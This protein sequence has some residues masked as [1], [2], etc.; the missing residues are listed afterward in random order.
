MIYVRR[1]AAVGNTA[2]VICLCLCVLHLNVPYAC[3]HIPLSQ[4]GCYWHL[5]AILGA[6]A[7]YFISSHRT[8]QHVHL[9]T[10]DVSYISLAI[11]TLMFLLTHSKTWKKIRDY[12]NFIIFMKN[13]KSSSSVRENIIKSNWVTW[14]EPKI[15]A[16]SQRK[17]A[18]ILDLLRLI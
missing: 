11:V 6:A 5:E 10:D 17:N 3:G 7:S 16:F 4:C 13:V 15:E 2:S 18:Q 14:T 1:T 12:V 8:L 9:H